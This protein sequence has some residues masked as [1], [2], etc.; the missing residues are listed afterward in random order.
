MLGRDF[1]LEKSLNLS[2][3]PGVKGWHVLW[4]LASTLSLLL[5]NSILHTKQIRGTRIIRAGGA[6]GGGEGSV[7]SSTEDS[8]AI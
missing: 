3:N 2:L 6:G 1:E 4:W 5:P 8:I 7:I